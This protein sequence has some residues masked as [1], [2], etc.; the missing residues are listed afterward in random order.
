MNKSVLLLL[1]FIAWFGLIIIAMPSFA[2]GQAETD[3]TTEQTDPTGSETIKNRIEARRTALKTA[4]DQ[5]RKDRITARCEAA[6]AKLETRQESANQV[7]VNRK[8][9]YS[10]IQSRLDKLISRLDAAEIDTAA[11]SLVDT[12]LD[13]LI[14]DFQVDFNN[15]VVALSDA[16]SI[17]C[18]ADTEGFV[19]AIEDARTQLNTSKEGAMAIRA[20]IQNDIK[21]AL[22]DIK[23][24]LVSARSTAQ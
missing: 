16:A 2:Q 18:V 21:T 1:G 23:T 22:T 11:L 5:A 8:E 7:L 12:Q 14:A 20:L 10:K 3:E 17:D 4:L 6:Q 24:A 9:R 15:Y 13:E 19:A